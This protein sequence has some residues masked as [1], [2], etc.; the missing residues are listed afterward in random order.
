VATHEVW[1]FSEKSALLAELIAAAWDLA[2]ERHSVAVAVVIGTRTEAQEAIHMGAAKVLWLGEQKEAVLVDDYIPTLAGIVRE[3]CPAALLI[4]ATKLGKAIAGRLAARIGAS[5]V[6]DA[7]GFDVVDD[8]LFTK[9]MIFG[10]GAVRMEK[11]LSETALATVRLGTYEKLVLD[12][13]RK[14][15][16]I[17]VPFVQPVSKVG[18]LVSRKKKTV[19]TSN[20]ASA[21]L[22]VC[23]GRGICKQ[24]DLELINELSR[25]LDAEIG[26]TRPLAEGLN[27]LP[28]EC[29]IGVSGASIKPEM[30]LGIGVSGQ[31][32]HTVGMIGSRIVVAINKDKN[33][34]IFAQADYGIVGD[35]YIV[36]PA[37]IRALNAR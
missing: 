6:T 7:E 3:H 16:I 18:Y 33:A 19:R 22:I 26:C 27:W 36:V 2:D 37:L 8:K 10:G 14:G 24:E 11:S 32:Q 9:H 12:A 30:Y 5:T 29:Y 34:P 1:A 4:G 15:E 21:K 25:V 31:V 23:P 13:E 35:L 28:R 17:E 20:L